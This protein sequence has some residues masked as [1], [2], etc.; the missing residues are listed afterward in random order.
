MKRNE[1]LELY[2]DYL[3]SVSGIA[4]ATGLSLVS[5]N[6]VSHDSVTRFLSY[7]NYILILFQTADSKASALFAYG[8]KINS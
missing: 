5:G 1:M 6:E 3:L 7:N 8:R 4:S 2:S